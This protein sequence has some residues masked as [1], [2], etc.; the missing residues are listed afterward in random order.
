MAK[1]LLPLLRLAAKWTLVLDSQCLEGV[2]HVPMFYFTT[3][4]Q[5]RGPPNPP[6]GS[7]YLDISLLCLVL[8]F[9]PLVSEDVG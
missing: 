9:W 6:Q 1:D 3:G 8:A 7:C 4:L 2:K 5:L